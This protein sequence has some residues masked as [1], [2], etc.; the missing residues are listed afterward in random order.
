MKK[1]K[2]LVENSGGESS[3]YMTLMLKKHYSTQ[4][5]IVVVFANTGEE[6]EETLEFIRLCDKYL[7]FNTIWVEAVFNGKGKGTSHKV[8]NFNSAV[9]GADIF[10]NMCAKYGIPNMMYKHCTR[11]LKL[12][13]IHHYIKSLGWSVGDYKTA[14]GI[15]ADEP[16]R[17]KKEI[18][19][20][21]EIFQDIALKEKKECWQKVIHPMATMF[22]VSKL[23]I[24]DFWESQEFRLQLDEHQGNCKWCYK[25]SLK[26]HYKLYTENPKQFDTPML[27]EDKYGLV[28][29]NRVKNI[30][31]D[32]PRKIF[33]GFT[34]TKSLIA[35]FKTQESSNTSYI[36]S[37]NF[38]RCANEECSS[39][40]GEQ[41][42]L[43]DN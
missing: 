21:K 24:S 39:S 13:P 36:E 22:P 30:L 18:N 19:P 40:D 3:A 28:G 10:E 37:K 7:D 23:D 11:E 27:L 35:M 31:I 6:N 25:K 41:Y 33:R 2:L 38:D 32:E 16:K 26:K 29:K 12:N 8:V 43:F 17:H 42:T 14:I 9:R 34:S 4:Y 15:R 20:T 5:E 1:Q